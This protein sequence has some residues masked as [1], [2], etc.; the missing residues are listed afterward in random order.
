VSYTTAEVMPIC[1]LASADME[2]A[3]LETTDG[4]EVMPLDQRCPNRTVQI[5]LETAKEIRK[6]DS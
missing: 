3:Q 1:T 5:G 2:H 4:L 6:M